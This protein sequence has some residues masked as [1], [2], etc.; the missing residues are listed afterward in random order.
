MAIA[1]DF[2]TLFLFHFCLFFNVTEI[3]ITNPERLCYNNTE[4]CYWI[5]TRGWKN[6]DQARQFCLSHGGD[7]A[8]METKELWDFVNSRFQ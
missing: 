4:R 5:E 8:V 7:L 3:E 6:Y 2:M 1:K